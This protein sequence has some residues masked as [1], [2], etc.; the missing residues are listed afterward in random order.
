MILRPLTILEIALAVLAVVVGGIALHQYEQGQKA[1]A[2]AQAGQQARDEANKQAQQQIKDLQAQ[3]EQVKADNKAQVT[4]LVQ[5]VASLKTPQQQIQWSQQQL[6]DAIKGIQITVNPKTGEATATIPA[7]SI[8]Q[9]PAVIEKCKTC[10]LNLDS[11]AKQLTFSQQQQQQLAN[12]L[13][14]VTKERDDWHN[15][16]KGGN[17]KQR[18][19]NTIKV[20]VPSV[21]IGYLAGHKF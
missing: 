12:Q 17:W 16:A 14:N 1:V 7:E 19:W 13:V 21:A 5:T 6:V 4:A 15:A 11:T 2:V 9:L 3:I 18:T 8:P 20:V 10:E